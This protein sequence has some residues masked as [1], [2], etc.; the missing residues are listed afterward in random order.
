MSEIDDKI[1]IVSTVK[2]E[3]P[4]VP[5]YA[6]WWRKTRQKRHL[7]RDRN[8]KE[9]KAADAVKYN[10]YADFHEYMFYI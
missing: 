10:A 3:M 9:F 7:K 5:I 4:F 8:D 6:L 1:K 2:D